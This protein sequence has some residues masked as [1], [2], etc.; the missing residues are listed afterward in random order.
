MPQATPCADHLRNHDYHAEDAGEAPN[1]GPVPP[2]LQATARSGMA[3]VLG[4]QR[5]SPAGIEK[6]G[7]AGD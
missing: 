7:G 1:Q 2:I 5:P 3:F 4:R 6:A